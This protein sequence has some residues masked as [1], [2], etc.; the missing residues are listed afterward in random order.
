MKKIF[1]VLM[2]VCL[3][4]VAGAW[5]LFGGTGNGDA[6]KADSTKNLTT[7]KNNGHDW[8]DLGLPS[9]LKWATCNVGASSPSDYGDCYAWGEISTISSFYDN[10]CTTYGK[11]IGDIAGNP[12]YDVAR[13]EWRGSWRLPTQA[14]YQELLDYCEW[15][16]T[17]QDGYKGYKVTSKKNG[18]SIFLPAT[19]SS[20]LG[21]IGHYWSATPFESRTDGAYILGFREDTRGTGFS[22]RFLVRSVRPVLQNN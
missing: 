21:S 15:E 2:A 6:S 10:G 17:T 22:Y 8:V 16:W 3:L 11:E 4:A 7:G 12:T 1:F 13:A 14:E 19:S 18:N 9:G 5:F 20:D